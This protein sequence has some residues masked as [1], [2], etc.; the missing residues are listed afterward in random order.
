[1]T[2]LHMISIF[3]RIYFINGLSICPCP[4]S[5]GRLMSSSIHNIQESRDIDLSPEGRLELIAR[6]SRFCEEFD[7]TNKTV[8]FAMIHNLAALPVDDA[9]IVAD[10]IIRLMD[11]KSL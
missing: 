10:R 3:R 2:H 4:Q 8:L 6:F 1:L 9:H 5:K 11:Q 7:G